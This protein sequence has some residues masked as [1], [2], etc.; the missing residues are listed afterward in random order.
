[1]AK[2][3]TTE[4]GRSASNEEDTTP[5]DRLPKEIKQGEEEK[6]APEAKPEKPETEDYPPF[7]GEILKAFPLYESLYID[8]HGGTFTPNTPEKVRA[9]APRY[10]NPYYKKS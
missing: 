7:V 1:M 5:N 9:K 2:R 4:E 8:A 6:T 10:R 3:I